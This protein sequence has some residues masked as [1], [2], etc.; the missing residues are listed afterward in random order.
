MKKTCR[1]LLVQY[2][3]NDMDNEY[4]ITNTINRVLTQYID[5]KYYITNTINMIVRAT[6]VCNTSIQHLIQAYLLCNE[7]LFT[8]VGLFWWCSVCIRFFVLRWW[9]LCIHFAFTKPHSIMVPT[10]M[11]QKKSA[12]KQTLYK[13][14][15]SY[16]TARLH[17][18][19]LG[20]NTECTVGVINISEEPD[21]STLAVKYRD[22]KL[23]QNASI[24]INNTIQPTKPE[25]KWTLPSIINYTINYLPN[26]HGLWGRLTQLYAWIEYEQIAELA[27]YSLR[28]WY[29]H[30][31]LQFFQI[32]WDSLCVCV[33]THTHKTKESAETNGSCT[34]FDIINHKHRK[35]NNEQRW[36]LDIGGGNQHQFHWSGGLL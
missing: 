36:I 2:M 27:A 29:F 25:L 20:C 6:P 12:I 14:W 24:T 21:V 9:C 8:I 7:H 30:D 13:I 22:I 15:G 26:L 10:S 23:F 32:L 28:S 1:I 31:F 35:C 19:L 3:D 5:K 17:Y 34:L 18:S 16:N 4:D 11:V 33:Y